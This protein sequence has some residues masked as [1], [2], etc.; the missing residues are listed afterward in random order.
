MTDAVE[1]YDKDILAKINAILGDD[2]DNVVTKPSKNIILEINK[3]LKEYNEYDDDYDDFQ[4]WY[5]VHEVEPDTYLHFDECMDNHV[6]DPLDDF[7]DDLLEDTVTKDNLKE[8]FNA[9]KMC[10]NIIWNQEHSVYKYDESNLKYVKVL[11]L[12]E[13]DISMKLCLNKDGSTSVKCKTN[14]TFYI[15]RDA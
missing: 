8:Y 5:Y 12:T 2:K 9:H 10:N 3:V 13:D 14:G 6:V 4:K 11:K 15:I 1:K 7:V